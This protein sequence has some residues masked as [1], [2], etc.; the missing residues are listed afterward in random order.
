MQNISSI[1]RLTPHCV[2]IYYTFNDPAELKTESNVKENFKKTQKERIREKQIRWLSLNG[3][4]HHITQ[5]PEFAEM[6]HVYDRSFKPVARD[7]YLKGLSNIFLSMVSGITKLTDSC[8]C[9]MG[10]LGN[11]LAVVHDIWTSITKNG[12]IGS[13][14]KITTS[15]MDTHIIATVLRKNNVSHSAASVADQLQQTYQDRYNIDLRKEAGHVTSD[16]TGSAHNVGA[17]LEAYQ[18]DCDMH[19][20]SLVINYSLGWN[21]NT[22]TR[23]DVDEVCCFTCLFSFLLPFVPQVF[24]LYSTLIIS[25]VIRQRFK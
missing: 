5:S 6:F 1:R 17:S 19:V 13:S 21:E 4:P 10:E 7:T 20:V 11:W 8:R 3:L 18:N 16:T 14:I 22:R 23:T 2:H 9:D 15:D 25:M 24:L 12:I